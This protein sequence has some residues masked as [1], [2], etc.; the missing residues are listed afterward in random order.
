MPSTS[1]HQWPRILELTRTTRDVDA[2]KMAGESPSERQYPATS[3]T[4]D[5]SAV[6]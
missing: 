6:G 3:S 2:E 5:S 1:V 4:R